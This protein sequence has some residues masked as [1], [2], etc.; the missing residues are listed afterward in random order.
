[1]PSPSI[2]PRAAPAAAL[3]IPQSRREG[4]P[5][6]TTAP[7]APSAAITISP[8]PAQSRNHSAVQQRR[9]MAQQRSATPLQTRPALLP[10]RQF[11]SHHAIYRRAKAAD[12][13][14]D[15]GADSAALDSGE[16]ATRWIDQ[17][18]EEAKDPGKPEA[19]RGVLIAIREMAKANI[20]AAKQAFAANLTKLNQLLTPQQLDQYRQIEMARATTSLRRP[21][22]RKAP[23]HHFFT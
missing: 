13:T 8:S 22:H 6:V 17:G 4:S 14:G 19:Q 21:S 12:E 3:P 11:A 9:A 15:G 5:D 16:D 1:M 23:D 20:P 10:R 7:S 2:P 18:L